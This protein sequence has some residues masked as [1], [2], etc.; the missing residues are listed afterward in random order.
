MRHEFRAWLD[1]VTGQGLLSSDSAEFRDGNLE[2]DNTF[3]KIGF[4]RLIRLVHSVNEQHRV[5]RPAV[6]PKPEEAAV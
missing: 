4:K 6:P 3:Q 2:F 1:V 5:V